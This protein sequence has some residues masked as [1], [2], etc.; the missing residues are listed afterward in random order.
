[1]NEDFHRQVLRRLVISQVVLNVA[2][3]ISIFV[4]PEPVEIAATVAAMD[5]LSGGPSGPFVIFFSV[6]SIVTLILWAWSLVQLYRLNK[7]GFPN[8]VLATVLS[9]LIMVIV[10]G[11]W[12]TGVGSLLLYLDAMSA[13]AII[14]MGVF[15]SD[16]ID[17]DSPG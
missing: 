8:F 1:M 13:G 7:R 12:I 4:F 16:A 5:E 17:D 3:L 10:G 2:L 14:C 15:F 6:F 9:C 11:G